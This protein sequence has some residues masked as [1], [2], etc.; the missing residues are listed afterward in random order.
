MPFPELFGH[1]GTYTGTGALMKVLE[2][3]PSDRP[4]KVIDLCSCFLMPN[5]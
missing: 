1:T 3:T 5:N 2:S 4:T